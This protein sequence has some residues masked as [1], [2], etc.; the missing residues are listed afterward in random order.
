MDF[1]AFRQSNA[2]PPDVLEKAK[3]D[4]DRALTPRTANGLLLGLTISGPSAPPEQVFYPVS[5]NP[6]RTMWFVEEFAYGKIP[7]DLYYAPGREVWIATPSGGYWKTV[8]NEAALNLP[9][10]ERQLLTQALALP[11]SAVPASDALPESAAITPPRRVFALPQGMAL[12]TPDGAELLSNF[13]VRAT[14]RIITKVRG[15]P[16]SENFE[17]EICVNDQFIGQLIV[18]A[19]SLDN[20]VPII[21]KRFPVCHTYE[22][23]AKANLRI[24]NA[25][26]DQIPTL[27]T[28]IVVK[29]PGF[30]RLNG[31]WVYAHD[32][33][34][35]NG[36]VEFRT[37]CTIPCDPGISPK[38]ALQAALGL[39]ELAE[40]SLVTLPLLLLAHQG[41]LYNLFEKAGVTPKAPVFLN[42]ETGSFK[43]SM[44]QAIFRP[45]AEHPQSPEASFRDTKTALEVKIGAACSRVFVVDDYQPPVT[46]AAGREMLE[47]LELIIRMFGDGVAKSRSNSELGRAKEFKPAGCC[48]IT[49]EDT[50]G[51]H[52]TLLRCLILSLQKG[53]ISGERLRFYQDHPEYLRAHWYYFLN[54]AGTNGDAII[55]FIRRDFPR[56]REL[57]AAVVSEPR[58]VD[59]GASFMVVAEILLTYAQATAD[60]DDAALHTIEQRWFGT[61]VEILRRSEEE[62]VELDPVRMYLE[63]LFDLC[64]TGEIRIAPSQAEFRVG[65]HAGFFKDGFWWL[66]PSTVY[67]KVT[68]FWQEQK[69][70]F[71]LKSGKLHA[72]L[73][74]AGLIET[75]QERRD[76]KLKTLYSV[77]STLDGRPRLLVLHTEQARTYFENS[78]K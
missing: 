32:G 48:L 12:Q 40:D 66:I 11:Q 20:T 78:R 15:E 59:I 61:L 39:L 13:Q 55:D 26:R 51:S 35:F 17:L 69:V 3:Q 75:S 67:A 62:T 49:G 41:F 64:V 8:Y 4:M 28:I 16:D 5:K 53:E 2:L 9:P 65:Y 1:Y 10:R 58:Q 71:P 54:W 47:K 22:D 34:A 37:G 19:A 23:V 50:G 33:A 36:P 76:G 45:F 24:A 27:P 14:G 25:I 73:A 52:S 72:L 6:G 42:G 74:Q 70:V 63:A 77:K 18:N 29:S 56:E 38:D 31:H 60:L 7:S 21:S 68:R 44:A 46:A 43:T 57:F 30:I